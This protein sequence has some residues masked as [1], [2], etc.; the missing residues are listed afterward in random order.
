[1]VAVPELLEDDVSK[2]SEYNARELAAGRLTWE[3]LIPLIKAFQRDEAMAEDGA[4]GPATRAALERY[5]ATTPATPGLPAEAIPV[6]DVL[7]RARAA[8]ELV[9]DYELGTGG[10]T[11]H[12]SSPASLSGQCDCSG[13]V[14]W[15]QF[16][17]R[18]R[19][20]GSWRF[21][22]SIEADA[23]TDGGEYDRI[24][25]P[26]PGCVIVYGASKKI[27]HVGI[28]SQVLAS[29]TALAVM[30]RREV[31]KA[32]RVIHCA[33]GNRGRTSAGKATAIRETDGVALGGDNDTMV[34]ALYAGV[35][36]SAA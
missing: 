27:G 34:F 16:H 25:V 4:A 1:V 8:L 28:V 24:L 5:F 7:A 19:L 31:L 11:P 13:F 14:A 26:R 3:H 21:T 29:A 6:R 12:D 9:I 32:I 15:C 30:T 36:Y 23:R 2:A 33:S 18:K 20:D 35:D 10:R 17:D 22:D